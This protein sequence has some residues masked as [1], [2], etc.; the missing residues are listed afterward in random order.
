MNRNNYFWAA[1]LIF[2]GILLLLGNLGI[3][4]VNVWGLLWPIFLILAGVW[5]LLG[6]RFGYPTAKVEEVSIS[7]KGTARARVRI[8]H[9]AGRLRLDDSANEGELVSGSFGGGLRYQTHEDGNTLDVRMRPGV[10]GSGFITWAPGLPLNW[11]FGLSQTIPLTL[12]LET[13][14]GETILDLT[15]LQVL[16]FHLQT[17]ASSSTVTMPARAGMTHA[18]IEAGAAAVTV[19]IPTGV[20]ARIR[21]SSGLAAI[22]VDQERFPR[23]GKVYLSSDYETAENKIDLEIETGVSS[24]SVR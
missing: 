15:N 24:V 13:G 21:T 11:D 2:A 17:G 12:D 23:Q 9:G 22:T 6:S 5:F 3:L 10:H 8:S 19:H 16:D 4:E 18:H 7:L 20:A 14:A 1:L